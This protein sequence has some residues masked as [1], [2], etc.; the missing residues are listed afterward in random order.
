M[1][2]PRVS[3]LGVKVSALNMG[4]AL[5]QMQTWINDRVPAYVCVAPAH[6][7]MDCINDSNLIPVFNSASMVTP[8]GMAV[9]WL[10]K[11]RGYSNVDRV[12]GPDLLL[13]AC[14]YGL[15]KG[16]RHYFYGG[17]PGVVEELSAN[18][19]QHY[20]GLQIAGVYSPPFRELSEEEDCEVVDR[21]NA[22]QADIVWVGIGSPRQEVWMNQHL[23]RLKAP[24]QIGVGAAFDFH[25]RR[26]K[27]AP[28]W[29]QRSG[30][31]WLFRLVTEPK[32]LWRR[33]IQYPLFVFLVTEQLIGLRKYK[34]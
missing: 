9:V 30:L 23:D 6:S 15:D 18:L 32:R 33:Y 24:V 29:I 17:T 8:D 10:L 1:N 12:Y 7:I 28:R 34:E 20:P 21:I 25:A 16:W 13:S 26:K 4:L 27:Q 11:L 31:E 19:E 14:Q 5:T 22:S 3:I 2:I